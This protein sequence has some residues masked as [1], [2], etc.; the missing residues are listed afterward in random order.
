MDSILSISNHLRL[1]SLILLF[2]VFGCS[3]IKKLNPWSEKPSAVHNSVEDKKPKV[4]PNFGPTKKNMD[5]FVDITEKVGL[6]INE[7][8]AFNIVDL[9]H[10]GY[11]EIVVIPTYYSTPKVYFFDAKTMKYSQNYELTLFDEFLRVSFVLFEDFN[12][13]GVIDMLAIVAN[14]KTELA[15][16]KPI[17]FQGENKK[18][19]I[20]F[21][22]KTDWLSSP[23]HPTISAVPLDFNNDGFLDLYMGN[24]FYQTSLNTLPLADEFYLSDKKKLKPNNGLLLGEH[25]KDSNT[26]VYR[27]ARPTYGLSICDIDL[28]NRMDILT[29][30]TGQYP[31]KLWLNRYSSKSQG[32]RFQDFG[33]ETHYSDDFKGRFTQRGGGRSFLGLCA[34]YNN[35]GIWDVFMAE[36]NHNWDQ[37]TIDRS[38][39]LTGSTFSFPPKFFRTEYLSDAKDINWNQADRRGIWADF[40]NDGLLDLLVDNSGFPPHS[41]LI[42]FEQLP[43]HSFE[44]KSVILGLD[45]TNPL[46]TVALDYNQDGKMDILSFQTD[47][48]DKR[49]KKR[50]YLFKNNQVFLKKRAFRFFLEGDKSNRRGIGAVIYFRVKK[51]DL[52]QTKKQIVQYSYG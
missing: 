35:D 9:N 33:K 21:T 28:N 27:N 34:D 24:W 15:K 16:I 10:D 38:S 2:S 14:Q 26:G 7:A 20:H 12:K 13:D 17:I 40:N 5:G 51:L 45:I 25:D 47:M 11:S 52:I 46:N 3:Q 29:A 50:A 37:E 31:N 23:A 43:D 36:L 42:L 39:L 32:Y 4:I 1:S 6:N 22:K 19:I 41:K 30:A 49:I 44:D 18:G 48:R 8:V